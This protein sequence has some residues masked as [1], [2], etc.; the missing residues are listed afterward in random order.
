MPF[1]CLPSVSGVS[2][3]LKAWRSKGGLFVRII[4]QIKIKNK[5]RNEINEID[6]HLYLE[7]L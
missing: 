2:A 4:R 3:S 5:K 7:L 1:C 6:I